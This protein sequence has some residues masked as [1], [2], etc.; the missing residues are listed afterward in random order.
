MSYSVFPIL[1]EFD[2]NFVIKRNHLRDKYPDVAFKDDDISYYDYDSNEPEA[3]M[4][5]QFL[6]QYNVKNLLITADFG[7]GQINKYFLQDVK[8]KIDGDEYYLQCEKSLK[9]ENNKFEIKYDNLGGDFHILKQ[10]VKKK[11][12]NFRL[13]MYFHGDAKI[14]IDINPDLDILDD[15]V[16]YFVDELLSGYNDESIIYKHPNGIQY[17]TEDCSIYKG[18]TSHIREVKSSSSMQ[19]RINKHDVVEPFKKY[20]DGYNVRSMPSKSK[21]ITFEQMKMEFKS[22]CYHVINNNV[23]LTEKK[24]YRIEELKSLFKGQNLLFYYNCERDNYKGDFEITNYDPKR[25]KDVSF[26]NVSIKK[27]DKHIGN[28]ETFDHVDQTIKDDI[29]KYIIENINDDFDLVFGDLEVFASELDLDLDENEEYSGDYFY[30]DNAYNFGKYTLIF[31]S[32]KY[33]KDQ[34]ICD[35]QLNSIDIYKTK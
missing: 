26:E 24:W 33:I 27:K 4:M 18:L 30:Y 25:K 19:F 32:S 15:Y 22:L 35:L 34:C 8:L 7:K 14:H 5:Q 3:I 11:D 31:N 1:K 23:K 9:L 13:Y 6:E 12:N 16:S 2:R 21:K 29:T 20:N 28:F 10:S 17:Y